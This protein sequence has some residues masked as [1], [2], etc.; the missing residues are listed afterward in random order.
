MIRAEIGAARLRRAL[1]AITVLVDTA[2]IRFGPDGMS[3]ETVDPANVGAVSVSLLSEAFDSYRGDPSEI[4]VDIDRVADLL[5][6]LPNQQAVTLV[7]QPGEHALSIESGVY[8]FDCALIDPNSVQSGKRA[9]EIAPPA[10]VQIDAAEFKRAIRMASM[11]SEEVVL[12][13]DAGNEVFYIN[14]MGD[15]DNMAVSY[16]SDDVEEMDPEPAHT[17]YG[18]SYLSKIA[19]E[20]QPDSTVQIEIGEEYPARIQFEI[21]DGNGRVVYGLAPRVT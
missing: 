13:V 2:A 6:E 20:I 12:G 9:A 21:A 17:I 16:T 19:N 18:T 7:H 14:A 5:S 11:F 15:S 8:D 1:D 4:S 3:V 10:M